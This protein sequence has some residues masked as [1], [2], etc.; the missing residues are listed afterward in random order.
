MG[1]EGCEQNIEG[2]GAGQ[3]FMAGTKPHT[4][5]T[6]RDTETETCRLMFV[7]IVFL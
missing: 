5:S 2:Q 1:S 7:R 3:L 4:L 6:A